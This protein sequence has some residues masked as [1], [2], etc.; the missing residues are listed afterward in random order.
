MYYKQVCLQ[1]GGLDEAF[2]QRA[3]AVILRKFAD[4]GDVSEG[5]GYTIRFLPDPQVPE[6]G[7]RIE[8]QPG[9]SDVLA[10]TKLGWLSGAG[11]VMQ[12]GR[13][14]EDGFEP[15]DFSGSFAPRCE[16]CGAY[17]ATHFG[18][19]YMKAPF[20][21]L[22]E[23]I[24]ELALFGGQRLIRMWF[25]YH[26]YTGI[27]D[28]AAQEV[29]ER[30]HF[31]LQTGKELGMK[32]GL[33]GP[34]NEGYS[35]TPD[36]LKAEWKVQGK[37]H[38]EPGSHYHVEV[39]PSRPGGMELILK[40][41]RE[42]LECFSDIGLDLFGFGVYD[43]GGCTCP[44]CEP[45]GGKAYL[46]IVR[47][48]TPVVRELFPDCQ[49]NIGGW[50]LD[51][52]VD[53]EWKMV[54]DRLEKEQDLADSIRYIAGVNSISLPADTP[55][56]ADCRGKLLSGIGPGRTKLVGFPEISMQGC[57]P[58]GGFG[59]NPYP[60][61]IQKDWD[62][63]GHTQ[64][65]GMWSYSEGFFEDINKYI[66]SGLYSGRFE[67]AQ[68]AMRA[69]VKTEFSPIYTDEI[70]EILNMME[71]TLQRTRCNPDGTHDW[72]RRGEP[73]PIYGLRFNYDRPDFSVNDVRFVIAHPEKVEE[74]M[75]RTLAVHEKLPE[76]VRSG[77]RWQLVYIRAMADYELKKADYYIR[78]PLEKYLDILNG[79]YYVDTDTRYMICAPTRRM[80]RELF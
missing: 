54:Y 63:T 32:V 19:W 58:W 78:E 2:F 3:S 14:T 62:I 26:H 18:N 44:L 45:Y 38:R 20:D 12:E 43:Q 72:R 52:F 55:E 68:D 51:R 46:N 67:T 71:E 25:D 24:E 48:V 23:Y 28:P 65:G 5:P 17:F 76:R 61:R 47:R 27:D 49:I 74:V 1:N 35:T 13:I 6:D 21:E 8:A 9:G 66:V 75:Q 34:A 77:W 10:S 53:G 37:Y 42:M 73:D 15:G 39:C 16:L 56:N 4:L 30:L 33:G 59:A 69:Y 29:I 80:I 50:Y 22:R 64:T 36:E 11:R 60:E 31:I 7:Y 41:R 57:Y 40:N 70:M 79:M